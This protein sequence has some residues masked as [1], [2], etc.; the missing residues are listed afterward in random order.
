[1]KKVL[2]ATTA[3]TLSAGFAA[4][5]GH[6]GMAVTGSAEMGV[7]DNG[8]DDVQFHTDVDVSFTGTGT[9]DNGL[10]FGFNIDLDESIGDNND[11]DGGAES[12]ATRADTDHGG[13]SIFISGDFGTLTMGDTDG[14]FDW[15]LT[16]IV[17]GGSIQ[18][19]EEHGAY[20]GNG[21]LDGSSDGQILRYDNTI[22]DFSFAVSYEQD[23]LGLADTTAGGGDVIGI[24]A[25]GSFGDFDFG[26]GYQENDADDILGL[27]VGATFGSINVVANAWEQDSG[28]D[29][30]GL[31]V[32]YSEGP[33]TVH[34]NAAELSGVSG[35]GGNV[36]YDL[37]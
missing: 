31:G 11:D 26:L 8:T 28:A 17:S 14:A 16:E 7:F 22:G 21:G 29:Y 19:N 9:T 5:D 4:A 32:T 34:V 6:A 23:D 35:F 15:A 33:L 27:S 13:A 20:D 3:L 37:G 25:K 1:M 10:T 2:L 36:G 12:K 30:V 18:D 24:G